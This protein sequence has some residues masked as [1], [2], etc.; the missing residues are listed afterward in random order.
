MTYLL[1]SGCSFTTENYV[2]KTLNSYSVPKPPPWKMWPQLIGETM[3]IDVVNLG[4]DGADNS[5]ICNS[6]YNAIVTRGNPEL[7][8]LGLS[9]W[10]RYTIYDEMSGNHGNLSVNLNFAFEK[11]FGDVDP[12]W[13]KDVDWFFHRN[14]YA[15]QPTSIE[16]KIRELVSSFGL[17]LTLNQIYEHTLRPLW[18]LTQYCKANKIKLIVFQMLTCP[19]GPTLLNLHKVL[20]YI[21]P[22]ENKDLH[23]WLFDEG[24][25]IKGDFE[26]AIFHYLNN[27]YYNALNHV[28]SNTSINDVNFIGWPFLSRAILGRAKHAELLHKNW[29]SKDQIS[30]EENWIGGY[31]VWEKVITGY[32]KS[33]DLHPARARTHLHISETNHHPNEFGQQLIAKTVLDLL[34]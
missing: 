13:I 7:I 31:D 6:V 3:G 20:K 8:M 33:I 9:S 29:E 34:K 17:Q 25:S 15:T 28:L 19:F 14:K 5:Y 27:R 2:D 16:F 11:Q 12:D 21:H 32:A 10:D 24:R 1:A 26:N 4:R 23:N 30:L 22:I 18:L